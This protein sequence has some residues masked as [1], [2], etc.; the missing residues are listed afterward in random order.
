MFTR[1]SKW[2]VKSVILVALIGILMGIFYT[3]GTNDLYN[4]VKMLLLPTGYAPATDAFFAGLWLM[5][6]P[7]AMYF[8]PTKGSGLVGELL[9]SIVEMACGG[10]WGITT[11]VS[12]LMQGLTNEIGFFPKKSRYQRFSWRS[13]LTGSFFASFGFFIPCYLMYGWYKFAVKVQIV[14]FFVS[15]LSSVLFDGVL[16]KLITNLFD[17]ALKPKVA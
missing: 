15:I 3:Y 1:S 7:L 16:V 8:V 14:M 5:A 17:R 9:A 6:A 10:Q 13:V 11:V 2:N 4:L 12:G